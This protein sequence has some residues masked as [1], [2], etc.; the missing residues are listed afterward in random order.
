MRQLYIATSQSS[1]STLFPGKREAIVI[2]VN[3]RLNY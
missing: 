3:F 1:L 2:E